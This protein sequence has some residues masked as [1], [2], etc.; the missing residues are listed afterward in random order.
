[1]KMKKCLRNYKPEN[2]G[3]IIPQFQIYQWRSAEV[4]CIIETIMKRLDAVK[5]CERL[6][7]VYI[8]HPK[9]ILVGVVEG[10]VAIT[11]F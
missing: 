11:I 8:F 1:M 4:R 5:F 10:D 6:G 2:F 9:E 7:V 3:I